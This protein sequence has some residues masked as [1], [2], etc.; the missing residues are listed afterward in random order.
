MLEAK[1]DV[2]VVGSGIGGLSAA[3]SARQSG[4]DVVVVERASS[5]ESGGNTRYTEAWLRMASIDEPAADFVNTL[6]SDF[7]GYPDP[8]ILNET[9][10]DRSEWTTPAA[11]LNIVDHEIVTTLASEAGPTLTWISSFGVSFSNLPTPFPTTSTSR[12]C[13]VGGGLALV[14]TLGAAAA[15]LGVQFRYHTTAQS[16]TVVDG[17]VVGLEAMGPDGAIRIMGSVVLAC[18][19]YEGNPEMLARYQGGQGLFTRPVAKGGHYNKGEGIEMAL[20]VGATTSG[21]FGLFHAEPIDP[22]SGQP[23]AAI[24][25]FPYGILVNSEGHRFTDEA[26]GPVD[27]WYER[28]TRKIHAQTRGV[29]YLILD[30][31]SQ[32]IPNLPVGLR[33]D[34]A[35]IHATDIDDLALNLEVPVNI[36]RTTIL[37]FNEACRPGDFDS[38]KPDGLTTEGLEPPK[39]NW[40]RPI[41]DGPYHAYPV[42]AANVFTFGGLRTNELAQVLDRDGTVINGLYAAGEITGLYYTNYTGSTSVLR[43][44]VFGRIAGEHASKQSAAR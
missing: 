43:G 29:A 17:E 27:A 10:R 6:I 11:T 41:D 26:P 38:T 13:P 32:T 14:E 12:L 39:S 20:E 3:L 35:P 23:E 37:G 18:G 36:L 28:I 25:S 22:R 2:I 5:E 31:K 8:G 1:Y 9:L 4:A 34:V 30:A 21:N 44:A 42:I 24:F 7:M 19:G 33:T 15:D 16:L 40:A